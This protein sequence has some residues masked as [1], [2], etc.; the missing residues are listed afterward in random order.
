MGNGCA[1]INNDSSSILLTKK[2]AGYIKRKTTTTMAGYI[3]FYDT[4]PILF[5]YNGSTVGEEKHN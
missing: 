2:G 1:S 4:L 5:F 3:Y